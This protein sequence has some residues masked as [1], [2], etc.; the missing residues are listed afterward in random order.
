[1]NPLGVT[2]KVAIFC[3]REMG[4]MVI[5]LARFFALLPVPPLRPLRVVQEMYY[6][7]VKSLFVIGLIAV[8]SGM[9]LSLQ[10]YY[11]LKGLG[12]EALLGSTVALSLI[13]E[14]GPVLGA[15]MVAARAGSAMAAEI[16]IMKISEQMDALD[17]MTIDPFKYLVVPKI[18]A[19]LL[20]MPLLVA[21]F[22]I[23]G[24]YSGYVIGVDLL[25]VSAGGYISSA[26]SGVVFKDIYVGLIKSLAFGLVLAWISCYKGFF[27]GRGAKGVSRATTE[28]VVM[29]SI[30]IFVWDYFLTSILL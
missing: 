26:T 9:V 14:L 18:L 11:A 20:V 16:G 29:S 4:R 24:I 28:A 27:C 23:I 5:F 25:G 3:L 22:D 15:I 12:S 8:F 19:G 10:G 7:G 30:M 17:V 21:I 13:R 6:V 1:M 2:G